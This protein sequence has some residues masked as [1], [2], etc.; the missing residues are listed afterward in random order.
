MKIIKPG[1]NPNKAIAEMTCT[2]CG[3]VFEATRDEFYH[4]ST[5]QRDGDIWS[6]NCPSEGCHIDLYKYSWE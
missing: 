5:N 4:I 2:R 6:I 3:C 1:V